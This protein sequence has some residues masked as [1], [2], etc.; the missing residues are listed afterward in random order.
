MITGLCFAYNRLVLRPYRFYNKLF[1]QF[2]EGRIYQELIDKSSAFSP[3]F[4]GVVARF[5]KMI[6]KEK[7]IEMS[8]KHAELLALQNQINPHFL[9]NTLD[10][11]RGDALCLGMETIADIAEALSTY[12]HYTISRTERLV[13]LTDE[14]ENI[15]N[16]F[17]IQQ[18]RFGDKLKMTID[19]QDSTDVSLMQCPKLMLQPIVENSI[20]HG[21]ESKT[22]GGTIKISVFLTDRN[23][24]IS[25]SDDGIGIEANKL[26]AI[27]KRLEYVSMSSPSEGSGMQSIAL[28]N[29]C[30]RIKLL[31]GEKYGIQVFSIQNMGTDVRITLPFIKKKVSHET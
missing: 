28:N 3:L 9:Y 24:L 4:Q 14:L 25:V 8:T 31:F 11:I 5:D 6:N 10:A 18:Y 26:D 17:K 16:Y 7:A 23:V 20:I 29:V 27:N 22:N 1:A 13:F 19:I 21:L 2:I 12:F 30:R 15:E